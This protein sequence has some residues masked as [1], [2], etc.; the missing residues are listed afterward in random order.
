MNKLL[1]KIKKTDIRI[2]L[3]IV[4]LI[5]ASIAFIK[6]KT[7]PL[8][9]KNASID[10]Q[11]NST[12]NAQENIKHVYFGSEK[13]VKIDTS[14]VNTK[15]LGQYDLTYT[16]KDKNYQIKVNVIDTIPPDFDVKSYK[17]EVGAE[18]NPKKLV[19]NIKDET[20]TKVY[21]KMHYLFD[22]E[23]KVDVCVVVEDEGGN[24]TEKNTTVTLVKDEEGPKFIDTQPINIVKNGNLKAEEKTEVKDNFDPSPSV[25]ADMS[26]VDISKPGK[27]QITYTATDRAGNTTVQKREVNVVEKIG[28]KKESKE[29]IVYLTFDD[30][31]SENT[32]KILKILD[33]Y[34]AKA[35]FFVTG[36]NHEYNYLLKR[37]SDEGHTIGL[38]TYTHDYANVYKSKKNY[39]KDLNKVGNMVK[40]YVG[41]FPRYIRFPGGSSN[42]IS[43]SYKKGIMTKLSKEVIN[44][45]FQYYDWNCD[46]TDASGNNVSTKKI[47]KNATSCKKRNINI[48][49]HDTD[50]KDTTVKALPKII[51]YYKS[52]GY[53][54]RAIDDSSYAPHHGINN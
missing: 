37:M 3:L 19:K 11:I 16:Y 2:I 40:S 45:G 51:K 14:K 27:Y 12:I 36:N 25:S 6:I 17:S 9:L 38:H 52:K 49:F 30:G 42:T 32:I 4:I 13:D 39:F 34:D 54:F 24:K 18:I 43:R 53:D 7:T 31:P 41:Y 5:L 50:A 23:G 47:I 48:L 8:V 33:K 15:K 46:S 10:T 26:N 44:R 21:F 1:Q 29:K 20:K 22:K 28:S 35:T